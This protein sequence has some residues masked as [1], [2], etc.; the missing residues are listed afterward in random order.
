MNIHRFLQ[1]H[2]VVERKHNEVSSKTPEPS[3]SVGTVQ[4]W[5]NGAEMALK[6]I[7]KE[8]DPKSTTKTTA[9]L[10]YNRFRNGDLGLGKGASKADLRLINDGTF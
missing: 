5:S 10:W 3:D 6:T 1:A 8:L 4:E 7:L 2:Q 9:S